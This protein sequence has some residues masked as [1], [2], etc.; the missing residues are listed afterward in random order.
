MGVQIR[1]SAAGLH[2]KPAYV[3]H[4]KGNWGPESEGTNYLKHPLTL[5]EDGEWLV[6]DGDFLSE[7][8]EFKIVVPVSGE[9]EAKRIYGVRMAA[10]KHVN[11]RFDFD[12]NHNTLW[13][14]A[15]SHSVVRPGEWNQNN[16]YV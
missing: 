8:E 4:E 14:L 15:V 1:I 16:V 10:G 7:R 13:L 6:S 5:S 11:T 12:M 3:A 2:G 9:E